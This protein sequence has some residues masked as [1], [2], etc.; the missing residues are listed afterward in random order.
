MLDTITLTTVTPT[1]MLAVKD[2]ARARR[3]YEDAGIHPGGQR[4]G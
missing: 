1:P 2:V 3:F 4:P